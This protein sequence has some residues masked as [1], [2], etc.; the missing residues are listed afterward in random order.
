MVWRF[1]LSLP[2]GIVELG[3][4][5]VRACAD[6]GRT[7]RKTA[8]WAFG[9]VIFACAGQAA[10]NGRFPSAN[11]LVVDPVDPAHLLVRSTFGLLQTFDAGVSWSWVCEQAV[12]ENGFQDPEALLLGDGTIVLGLVDGIAL[13]DRTGC[14]WSRAT[15]GIEGRA[16]N[17]LIRH[18]A[19]LTRAY[20]ALILPLDG[21][22]GG[23]VVA[24][25]DA[26][27]TWQAV[28][29]V[30]MDTYPVTLEIAASRPE[31]LYLGA[32]DSSIANGSIG[33]SDDGGK[34]FVLRAPPA[35]S[36]SI[37][38]S[39]VDP[40]NADRLYVRSYYPESNLYV[41]DDA[42]LSYTL[43]YRSASTLTGFALSPSG[44]RVAI[45][46]R[47][48]I[49]IL[50]RQEGDAGTAYS[51]EQTQ[52]MN[53]SCLGWTPR[54]LFACASESSDGFSV[55]ISSNFAQSFQPLLHFADLRPVA[56]P[57]D[58]TGARCVQSECALGTLFGASCEAPPAPSEASTRGTSADGGAVA[59]GD[60]SVPESPA[61]PGVPA[62]AV[63]VPETSGSGG[64]SANGRA[65]SRSCACSSAVSR[66]TASEALVALALC[67]IALLRSRLGAPRAQR[68]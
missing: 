32:N 13:G 46:D 6:P 39:G 43:L 20:A 45:G 48:S 24:T 61:A 4:T 11:Q 26:G 18:P 17:D 35:G 63:P 12:A 65:V 41:S 22:Y 68:E 30:L 1:Q 55:G 34:T 44:D 31:R 57:R 8:A 59:P 50:R 3:M 37:Y 36:D 58:T 7:R 53:V 60:A 27:R 62:P 28:S 67:A 47:D 21:L 14:A 29:D 25:D 42:G 40:T 10:A 52:P 64:T 23:Q 51:V 16:V 9:L 66:G 15:S 5:H 33:V 56:C 19:S 49:V 38:V 54:G 2:S